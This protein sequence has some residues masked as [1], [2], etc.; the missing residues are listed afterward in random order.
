LETDFALED[1]LMQVAQ[2]G[3]DVKWAV[4]PMQLDQ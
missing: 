3:I 1:N 2:W 4:S